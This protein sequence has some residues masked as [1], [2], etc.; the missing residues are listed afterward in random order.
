[1]AL[2]HS[3]MLKNNSGTSAVKGYSN[4]ILTSHWK[5]EYRNKMPLI[6][7]VSIEAIERPLLGL[8]HS[9]SNDLFDDNNSSFLVIRPQNEWYFAWVAWNEIL[10]EKHG[11]LDGTSQINLT[12]L[13]SP[14]LKKQFY[15]I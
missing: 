15:P 3:C 9:P 6:R 10:S 14:S 4:T 1:M 12:P 7:S 11:P 13:S 2:I 5:L 8:Q